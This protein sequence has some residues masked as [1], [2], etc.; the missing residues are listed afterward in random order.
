MSEEN[1]RQLTEEEQALARKGEARIAAAMA[2][3]RAP[4]ALR[5]AIERERERAAAARAPFWRR[6]RWGLATASVAA[7]AFAVVVILLETG[8]NGT[9]PSLSQVYTA[10]RLEPTAGAPRSLGGEPPVLDT[11]VENLTFPDWQ[12]SFAWR[13]VGRRENE[14]SGRDVTTVYYRNPDGAQLGYAVVAGEPL[15]GDPPG[16][17]VT[18]EGNTYS[19]ARGRDRTIVTWTQEGHTCAIV[20]PSVV[21]ATRLVDLA[22]SRNV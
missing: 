16:R 7:A 20:A 1:D 3:V 15:G 18:R 8:G 6:Y 5:E 17:E 14:L 11:K 4:Q 10:A 2:D 19:V 9:E 21:P 12:A 13:A 22:A